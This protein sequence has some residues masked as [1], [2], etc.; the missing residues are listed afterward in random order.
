MSGKNN[1]QFNWRPDF[2]IEATLPD[3]KIIRT[4]FAINAIVLVLVLVTGAL[5]VQREYQSYLLRRSVGELEQQVNSN[6]AENTARLQKN[7]EF[8][9]Q[10]RKIQELQQFFKV[11]FFEPERI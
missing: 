9:K 7:S 5:L 4:D 8:R 3:I 10:A 1:T 11:P 2:K 6:S